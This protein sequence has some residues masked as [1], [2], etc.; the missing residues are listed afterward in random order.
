MDTSIFIDADRRLERENEIWRS[1]WWVSDSQHLPHWCASKMD[2][3]GSDRDDRVGRPEFAS[4]Q[5]HIE[6]ATIYRAAIDEEG[7]KTDRENLLHLKIERR[8]H[9]GIPWWYSG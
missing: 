7:L 8:N 9:R 5:R 6:T 3:W 2:G 4:S 1:G